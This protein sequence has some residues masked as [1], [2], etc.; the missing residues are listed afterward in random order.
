MSAPEMSPA[1]R[2]AAKKAIVESWIGAAVAG[3]A[4]LGYGDG[5]WAEPPAKAMKAH[6]RDLKAR[7]L[8]VYVGSGQLLVADLRPANPVI[9][10][11]RPL[12]QRLV[13]IVIPEDSC[14]TS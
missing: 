4:A 1:V 12:A 14:A 8:H 9:V 5:Q 6:L 3:D 13:Q 2:A 7:G 10:Q 11:R